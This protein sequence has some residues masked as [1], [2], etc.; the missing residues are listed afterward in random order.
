MSESAP[1]LAKPKS[2]TVV[3]ERIPSSLRSQ[4]RWVLWKNTH[5]QKGDGQISWTKTPFSIYGNAAKTNESSTWCS[6]DT[7]TNALSN[8]NYDGIGFV[9][10]DEIH[11]I[12]LD[13][14]RDPQTGEL[15]ALALD[16]LEHIQGYAEVSPSG[17]GIK[18][19]AKTDLDRN[20]VKHDQGVELYNAGRYFTV[21]GH[22][23]NGHHEIDPNI[24][25]LNWLI[26]KLWPETIEPKSASL[27]H[28]FGAAQ[29][30]LTDWSLERVNEEI[31]PYINA[32]CGYQDWL[33]VGLA[34]HHQGQGAFDWLN[35]WD[36]WSQT[37]D[38]WIEGECERKWQSFRIGPKKGQ[39]RITLRT[40][41]KLTSPHRQSQSQ[42]KAIKGVDEILQLINQC[43]QA[44]ELEKTI[45]PLASQNSHLSDVERST[46]CSAI[47]AKLKELGKKIAIG[48]IRKWVG[49]DLATIHQ[50]EIPAWVKSWVYVTDIDKFF[51]TLTKEEVTPQGFKAKFN[52]F[53]PYDMNNKRLSACEHALEVWGIPTVAHKGYVP[54]MGSI[55]N[56]FD[57]AWVNSY[58]PESV[59]AIPQH[60]SAIDNANLAKIQQHFE[61][62]L[63]DERERHLLISFLAH[64]VQKPGVKIRWAP[65]I[66]GIEGD[67]KSF[68]ADLL[69]VTMG[70]INV[71]SINGSTL[72]SNFTDWIVGYAVV[73][74]EEMKQ[75][76][77]SRY[78]IMN[79]L[80][81]LITNSVIE[82]HPKGKTAYMAMN[83]ANFI[84]FSNYLDGAPI[85]D[86][87]RRYMFVSS[88]ITKEEA[89]T[90][91]Q[92][93]HYRE[94]FDGLV[95]SAGA[96]RAWLMDYP[97]HPE[98]KA[99]GRAPETAIK[100]TVIEIS[101]SDLEVATEDL[102]EQGREG[103]SKKIISSI[104][105]TRA[106]Q[107]FQSAPP[108]TTRVNRLIA[109]M[110]FRFFKRMRWN[111]T[112]TNVWVGLGTNPSDEAA[113][114]L[115]DSTQE[116]QGEFL[117]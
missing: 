94:L 29:P 89:I 106:L 71:R 28:D 68:F 52:R 83:V 4:S 33:N 5:R 116:G 69:A 73:A 2:L 20:R 59:P 42:L 1:Q 10:S 11:G 99:D 63:P 43:T 46:I 47:D 57:I 107:R 6:F 86:T 114:A 24:Q 3:P 56:V 113:I 101:K 58:R 87:D 35:A 80:K 96:I 30:T 64:N 66:H 55:F 90:L 84:I 27:D 54:S 60:P 12:D 50:R 51:D 36:D 110:G 115:L 103:I 78:D 81:P 62:Y 85:G 105:L 13:D 104:H 21:T 19:F 7:A 41:I 8:S 98:F 76:G 108:A 92:N 31:L 111:G 40:L 117:N 100:Q 72:E 17:T 112:I 25:S 67:G 91:N 49:K 26:N 14:C 38:K 95:K 70:G 39:S 9:L 97:L 32:D 18:I 102:I 88:A 22:A 74:I 53:M 16:V 75:H 23:L 15:S 61:L 45:A 109:S 93:G 34:L 48:T 44:I 82:V 77:H 65:Y 37:S 79:K